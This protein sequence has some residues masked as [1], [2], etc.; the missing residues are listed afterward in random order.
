[1]RQSTHIKICGLTSL[2]DAH[3]AVEAGADALGLNFW[4][5]TPR[6][7]DRRVAAAIASEFR[8]LVEL[9]GVFVDAPAE[10]VRSLRADLGLDWVQLHGAESAEEVA[11]LGPR[12]YKAV[13]VRDAADVSAALRF[14]GPRL[15]LDARVEGAMPGGTGVAFEWDLAVEVAKHRELT[16]AGGLNPD[17]VAEAVRRVQ[18]ARVDV[19]SGV[20]TRP[21]VKDVNAMRAFVEAVRGALL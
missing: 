14:P 9:V 8:G 4:P 21:G 18:P 17:N 6:R 12:A 5:G 7:I 20:E 19:A 13:G 10:D 15:L 1:M 16:L 3:A 11:A 2:E